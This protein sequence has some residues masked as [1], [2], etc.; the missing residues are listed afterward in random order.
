MGRPRQDWCGRGLHSLN[1][2][3]NVAFRRK[4][5]GMPRRYCLPCEVA[6][7]RARPLPPL[8]LAPTPGQ[9][10]V[11]QGRADGMTEEEIAERDGVTVDGVRQ[12][13]MRARRRLRV[14]PSLSAAVAVCLAYELITPDTSG[15]RPPKS[16]ETAPY[17]A[18]VLALVQGR[19][20]PMSPKDVQRLKLLDV[21]YA[22][23]EPHAVSVLWAAGTITPRDV[24]PLFAK[25]RKRQ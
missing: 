19:R 14:T 21:L 20:R 13:I 9:L 16:A 6:A 4:A 17:A 2:P 22:W 8:A 7:R 1:D 5:D 24:A 25:R 18:S 12:S 15:P 10:D 23:S 11:L 3:H